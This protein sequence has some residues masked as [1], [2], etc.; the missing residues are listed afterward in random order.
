MATATATTTA[1]GLVFGGFRRHVAAPSEYK[2]GAGG[3]IR[4]DG[5]LFTKQLLYH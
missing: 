5:Q 3:R 1:T 2:D 4:T